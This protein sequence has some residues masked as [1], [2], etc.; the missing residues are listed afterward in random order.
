VKRFI[1]FF[2]KILYYLKRG[3]IM[4]KKVKEVELEVAVK[5]EEKKVAD[6][7]NV[8]YGVVQDPKTSRWHV[9]TIRY[10]ASGEVG[11]V[12]LRGHGDDKSIAQERFKID[13]ANE[14]LN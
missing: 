2:L 1:A 10:N 12:Q 14:L 3:K 4:T 5:K 9:A 13:V 8:A 11:D 7:T 6:L